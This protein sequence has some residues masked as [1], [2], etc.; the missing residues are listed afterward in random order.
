MSDI[1]IEFDGFNTTDTSNPTYDFNPF[2]PFTPRKPNY[3]NPETKA[4]LVVGSV[5]A[6]SVLAFVFVALRLVS[7]I[8]VLK[9][10][11]LEDYLIVVALGM[12]CAMG[13]AMIKRRSRQNN[14]L[15][16]ASKSL[17]EYLILIVS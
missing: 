4:P 14:C 9:M 15:K 3:V 16:I 13:A 17:K 7:R 8:W 12:G 10:M 5:V 11:K 6:V 2:N 1:T